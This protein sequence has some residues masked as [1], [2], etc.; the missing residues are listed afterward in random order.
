MSRAVRSSRRPSATGCRTAC[1]R[2]QSS[3]SPWLENRSCRA[4]VRSAGPV[5]HRSMCVGKFG[6]P[7]ATR[8]ADALDVNR[9]SAPGNPCGPS[10]NSLSS[11]FPFRRPQFRT[12]LSHPKPRSRLTPLI[13]APREPHRASPARCNLTRTAEHRAFSRT[14]SVRHRN[15]SRAPVAII[16]D[17]RCRPPG[18]LSGRQPP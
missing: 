15:D 17:S 14:H 8:S 2:T 9:T 11:R 12:S 5:S 6:C 7:A 13:A 1:S 18:S 10:R 16:R 3:S 4:H